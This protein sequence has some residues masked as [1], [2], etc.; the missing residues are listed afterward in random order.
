MG[1][2]RF[3]L[4]GA[5]EE[6]KSIPHEFPR[7]Y[8]LKAAGQCLIERYLSATMCLHVSKAVIVISLQYSENQKFGQKAFEFLA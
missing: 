2:R 6:R 1:S 5:D 7:S 8:W 4:K 3:W